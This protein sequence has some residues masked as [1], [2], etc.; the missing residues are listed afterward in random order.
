[1][2][3][4]GA[5]VRINFT[6]NDLYAFQRNPSIEPCKILHRP[7]DTGDCWRF[8]LLD[9]PHIFTL[10]PNCSE[11]VGFELIEVKPESY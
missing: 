5:T 10:N 2:F 4:I 3:D 1:M 9:T 8:Q 6:R 11:F 7:Q